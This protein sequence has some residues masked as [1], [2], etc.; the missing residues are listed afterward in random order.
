MYINRINTYA[1]QKVSFQRRLT[2]DE[3]QD[4]KNNGIKP[5]LGYLGTKEVA[6]I[7]HGTSYPESRLEQNK[8]IN[9]DI[10]VGSP[11]GKVAAQLMPFEILHGFTCNQLGPIGELNSVR[12]YSPYKSSVGSKNYL[13]IDFNKLTENKY[14]H[15]LQ[16]TDVTGIVSPVKKSDD[17][18]AY[19]DF[20]EA[21][22]NYDSLIKKAYSN[23][24][25]K[26]EQKDVR[27]I[28]MSKEFAQFME[29]K[30]ETETYAL[31]YIL[32]D[33]YGTDDYTKWKEIDRNLPKNLENDDDYE[34]HFRKK[35]LR[36]K[37]GTKYEEYCFGQY[38]L[39]KQIKENTDLR[40][41]YEFK[42]ISDMLVGFSPADEWAHQDLFLKDYA[43]GC[44]YGGPNGG[45]QRWNV[46]VL[47]PKKLFN[48]DGILG[49]AGEY[50]KS[51][52]DDALDNF[53]NVRIDHVLG[54]VDPFI[55]SKDGHRQGN[56]NDMP[57][58]DPDKNYQKVLSKIILPTLEEHGI[59][60]YTPVWEDLVTETPTFLRI[61]YQ[62][63]GLP[64]ITPLEY[65]RGE[66]YK[67]TKNW[68]L[69]GSH[70]SD[71]AQKMIKKDWVRANEAWNPMYLAGILNASHDSSEYC[72]KIA[73]DDSERVKAKFAEL[74]MLGDK[75]QVS[76]ADFFGIDKTYNEGGHD[77]NP[78]N[79]K[80]RLNNDYE[81]S[82]YKNL[83]SEHP[84][85][86]NM[87]EVLKLAVQ[88]RADMKIA[89]GAHPQEVWDEA[90]KI[91]FVLDKYAQVLK[92]KEG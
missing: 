52:L 38:L 69:V 57:D 31:F 16:S 32:K 39:D 56:I 2:K 25:K 83:S 46:P 77:E 59:D 5:A 92:E 66:Y 80:L 45:I 67:D 55:Y 81:D 78:N 85:A 64:G 26:L 50:L 51:K 1:P 27:A 53:D 65:K 61:Y 14:G 29:D 40:K 30:P 36:L 70:D 37:T 18:Y 21:F 24:T 89:Q 41:E 22:A 62:E 7:L 9:N 3:E 63:N 86:I 60:K 73:N 48:D 68:A 49:S 47:N 8:K 28:Q 74:F 17:N 79:W 15:L 10:G 6:M 13:F 82:Y 75:V 34:S 76:F 44:P 4:Y 71:P 58:I 20:P 91:L 35:Q 12:E 88:G 19:S 11:Y 84:T 87:P 72:K 33:L 23:F 43:I 42:Y 54:L 90:G